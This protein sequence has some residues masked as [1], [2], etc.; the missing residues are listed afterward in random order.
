MS[1]APVAPTW[2]VNNRSVSL[3][4]PAG[5]PASRHV[6]HRVAGADANPYLVAALVLGA[7]QRGIEGRIDPGPPV[8]GNGYEQAARGELP[9]HWQAALDRA[10]GSEFLA[11]AMGPEFLKVFLAIKRQECEKFGALVSDRDY[12]WYL[13]SA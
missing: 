7:M 8:T 1:Y 13:D 3:R 12:E 2:G 10:A 5:P 9:T 6:E 11:W 4:I